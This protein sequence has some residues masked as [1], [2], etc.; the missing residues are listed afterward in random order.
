MALPAKCRSSAIIVGRAARDLCPESQCRRCPQRQ[1]IVERYDDRERL[2]PSTVTHPKPKIPL[3][4]RGR[5]HADR[6]HELALRNCLRVVLRQ[7]AKQQGSSPAPAPTRVSQGIFRGARTRPLGS[8]EVVDRRGKVTPQR[9]AK[10][11]TIEPPEPAS[12]G[13][14]QMIAS[15]SC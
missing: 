5:S 7:T 10:A 3:P 4:P 15:Y 12:E 8:R 14:P 2:A 13:I 9:W 6:R 11:S 1:I